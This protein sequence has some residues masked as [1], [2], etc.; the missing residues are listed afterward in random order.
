MATMHYLFFGF[1][2][3]AVLFF[4]GARNAAIADKEQ[5]GSY[6][7]LPSTSSGLE[8]VDDPSEKRYASSG[9]RE[10]I[11]DI[12]VHEIG[13]REATCHNDGKRV[14]EYLAY[15]GLGKGHA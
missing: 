3:V 15:T 14:E 13:V 8:Q 7:E 10:R 4:G 11:V 2:S 12:A 5:S 6:V 9:V 1:L